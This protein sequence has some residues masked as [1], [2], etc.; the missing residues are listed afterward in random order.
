M[1]TSHYFLAASK[2]VVILPLPSPRPNVFQF[3][4]NFAHYTGA[5]LL[6]PCHPPRTP[7]EV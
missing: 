1:A 6:A 7:K 2:L 4:G 5:E 3:V